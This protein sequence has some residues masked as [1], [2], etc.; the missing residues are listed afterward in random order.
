MGGHYGKDNANPAPPAAVQAIRNILIKHCGEGTPPEWTSDERTSIDVQLLEAWRSTAK[1]PESAVAWWLAGNT[2]AGIT[3][4]AEPCGIF[5]EIHEDAE[6]H[7][8][9]VSGN[10]NQF[11]NYAGVDENPIATEEIE[12][13]IKQGHLKSFDT[14]KE[15]EEFV[16][17]T[18]DAPALLAKLV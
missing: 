4:H 7:Y 1:D 14:A 3:Q 9:E 12:L 10:I 2:P 11:D 6:M 16:G 5:P 18:V 8:S 13:R 17:A 15:L